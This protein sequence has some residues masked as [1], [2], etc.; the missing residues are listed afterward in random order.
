MIR[1][2]FI[3]FIDTKVRIDNVIIVII[4]L[5][6]KYKNSI[7]KMWFILIRIKFNL[8]IITIVLNFIESKR[9]EGRKRKRNKLKHRIVFGTARAI[10]TLSCK[11]RHPLAPPH[12]VVS[13]FY[14]QHYYDVH[15]LLP[16]FIYN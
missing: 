6:E 14:Y 5:T 11:T 16:L 13:R 4:F 9:N 7:V 8:H 3:V 2:W 15:D 12:R 1:D 10:L